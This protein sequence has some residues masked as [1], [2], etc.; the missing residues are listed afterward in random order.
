MKKKQY[1]FQWHDESY[2]IS[3]CFLQIIIVIIGFSFSKSGLSLC[4]N[5]A[6]W[7]KKNISHSNIFNICTDK[8]CVN[9]M[10]CYS[11]WVQI[12]IRLTCRDGR[13]RH[14][15]FF[16]CTLSFEAYGSFWIIIIQIACWSRIKKKCLFIESVSPKSVCV[17]SNPQYLLAKHFQLNLGYRFD[18]EAQVDFPARRLNQDIEIKTP[19]QRRKMR[20]HLFIVVN[21]RNIIMDGDI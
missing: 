2:S 16:F 20:A 7:N 3:C 9:S 5:E 21:S 4:I 14:R 19:I 1:D 12:C 8:K 17:Q 6:K 15:I 10:T 11:I 13:S 18:V